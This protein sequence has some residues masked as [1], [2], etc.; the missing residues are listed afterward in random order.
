MIFDVFP[1]F[2][3]VDLLEIRL[4]VL[5]DFVDV[6][7]ICEFDTSFSGDSK[8][9]YFE[10]HRSRFKNFEHKIIYLKKSQQNI[11]SSFVNDEFQKNS[12]GVDLIDVCE[13]EDI[14]IFGDLDEIP[15][16]LKLDFAINSLSNYSICHFAQNNFMYFL[17]NKEISC[18]ILSF[19]GEY[20]GII[21]K[22]WLGTIITRYSYAKEFE[23]TKLRFPFHKEV[24]LRISDGGWHFSYVGSP[25][26]SAA[27][28]LRNKLKYSSHQ[29]FNN[30][31]YRIMGNVRL[32]LR[33]D[34]YGLRKSRF[35]LVPLDESFPEYILKNSNKY[36]YIIR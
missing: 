33:K 7:V 27:K 19:A 22:K 6:F 20:E 28:R 26:F 34:F 17:N 31:Y 10:I 12:I 1:F 15:N 30:Y 11:F 36:S 13:N 25:G 32:L 9:Y 4:N 16:P 23:L 24:G 3:E 18:N 8:P 14:V 21:E 5:D 29:E 2:N 35:K